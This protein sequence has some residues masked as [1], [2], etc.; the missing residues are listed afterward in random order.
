[1]IKENIRKMIKYTYKLPLPVENWT[2]AQLMEYHYK[3]IAV[4][5]RPLA[6][7]TVAM[8]KNALA[9]WYVANEKVRAAVEAELWKRPTTAPLQAAQAAAVAKINAARGG[10][11]F[12]FIGAIV[13]PLAGVAKAAINNPIINPVGNAVAAVTGITP[14]QQLAAGAAIGTGAGIYQALTVT[15]ASTAAGATS[16]ATGAST[17]ATLTSAQAL[18]LVGNQAAIDAY[19]AAGYIGTG[20]QAA[21][22]TATAISGGIVAGAEQGAT[23]AALTGGSITQGATSGAKAG[24]TSGGTA[25]AALGI[26]AGTGQIINTLSGGSMNGT[27]ATGNSIIDTLTAGINGYLG[28]LASDAI[29]KVSAPAIQPAPLGRLGGPTAGQQQQQTGNGSMKSIPTWAMA[30]GG[31]LLVVLGAIALRGAKA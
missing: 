19:A 7:G 24:A 6:G 20:T 11:G 9:P 29:A 31:L 13:S 28:A 27:T 30:A 22:T 8:I 26:N 15:G 16:T 1:M 23:V 4:Y 3:P 5:S 25:A 14:Q 18:S 12:G 21:L 17:G 2:D 10:G